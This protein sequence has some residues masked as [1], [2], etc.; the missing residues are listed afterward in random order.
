MAL[1]YS[2]PF[3]ETSGV[4]MMMG[5]ARRT[6]HLAEVEIHCYIAKV[7]KA[8]DSYN[9]VHSFSE[10]QLRSDLSSPRCTILNNL[11]VLKGKNFRGRLAVCRRFS[12]VAKPMEML[13]QRRGTWF[14]LT[15]MI[16]ELGM[17]TIMSSCFL[18][19]KSGASCQKT[20][21]NLRCGLFRD[22]KAITKSFFTLALDGVRKDH[23]RVERQYSTVSTTLC[24][25]DGTI[26]TPADCIPR[27]T[28]K[29]LATAGSSEM[30][31]SWPVGTAWD[32]MEFHNLNMHTRYGIVL[33]SAW[34]Q[35]GVRDELK[36]L[37]DRAVSLGCPRSLH[38]SAL[39]T[40]GNQRGPTPVF[41]E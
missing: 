25:S 6:R 28:L 23:T 18:T 24:L 1:A 29:I 20:N 30:M 14:D 36:S 4:Q 34:A 13:S 9:Y 22:C 32:V 3:P 27:Q 19:V 41:C 2:S 26:D 8:G 16:P 11:L 35:L 31:G 17:D 7:F 21:G 40:P 38:A 37:H 12:L 5:D 39:D 10:A 33:A 15:I